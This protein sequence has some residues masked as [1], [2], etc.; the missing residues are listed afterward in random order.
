MT[1]HP[2]PSKEFSVL[3]ALLM[4]IVAIS[5]D[6]LLPAL[7]VLGSE[8]KITNPNQVQLVIGCI[9]GG[10]AVGQ[11]VAGPFS[12]AIGRKP[13]LYTGIALYLA[14][15]IFC[16]FTHD[17]NLLLLGRCIQG[18]GVAGPYVTAISIVRDKYSG[19]HMAQIMSLVMMI[20]ILVPAVAPSLG[21]A[22]LHMAGWRAIFLL[23]IGYSL[24]VGLWIAL[25]LEETLA[26]EH[27]IPFKL[28]AFVHGFK[29]VISNRTTTLY[30]VCMGLC[31]GSLIGYL[32]ASQQ[33]FQDQF[34]VG[35]NFALYF[36]GLAL[37]IGISS[38]LNSRIVGKLGMRYICIRAM[39]TI[40]VASALFF[41]LHKLVDT[42]TL[43][44][45]VAYLAILFFCFGLMF[46]NLN[47]IA[48]EPMGDVAGMASAITGA[49]SSVIS[50]TLGTT[51]GQMYDGTLIPLSLGFLGLGVLTWLLMKWE[52]RLHNATLSA[53]AV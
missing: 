40:V 9:F 34:G 6:A 46:G 18:L 45:F 50:L 27:R 31:F 21:Q 42:V 19:R 32:G 11:L 33:I 7:G 25:R 24:L 23:Y 48:M 1:S 8:L 22:V 3:M 30:M 44:M 53:T 36:G 15:S 13:I 29:I 43:P 14:G 10:M 47:A 4:S 16:Y 35:D 51:I 38:L 12:D 28:S 26:P 2:I 5:I 39:G 52:Q 37:V 41:S 17:F 49:V 20:F